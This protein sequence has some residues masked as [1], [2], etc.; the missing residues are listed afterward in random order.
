MTRASVD[1]DCFHVSFSVFAVSLHRNW[2]LVIVYI[3]IT[4]IRIQRDVKMII[5]VFG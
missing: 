4:D 1:E 2:T 5:R 3:L